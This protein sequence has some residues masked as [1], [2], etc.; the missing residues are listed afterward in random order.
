L[1]SIPFQ[2]T[3]D[4]LLGQYCDLGGYSLYFA[5]IVTDSVVEMVHHFLGLNLCLSVSIIIA[6]LLLRLKRFASDL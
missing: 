1:I 5:F 3:F 2:L 6:S 4:G